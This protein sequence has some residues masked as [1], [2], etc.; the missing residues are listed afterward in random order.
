MKISLWNGFPEWI[1]LI[2]N[3][4]TYRKCCK[5]FIV[6]LQYIQNPFTLISGKN[7]SILCKFNLNVGEKWKCPETEASQRIKPLTS[8]KQVDL[9]LFF[10]TF[11]WTDVKLNNVYKHKDSRYA[12]I[13]RNTEAQER[14]TTQFQRRKVY[15]EPKQVWVAWEA[16]CQ[17]GEQGRCTHLGHANIFPYILFSNYSIA[18]YFLEALKAAC[19]SACSMFLVVSIFIYCENWVLFLQHWSRAQTSLQTFTVACATPNTRYT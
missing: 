14:S 9:L 1:R 5:A 2:Q 12:V 19:K 16:W 6:N 18:N 17:S 3:L 8:L 7:N 13:K 11:N 4:I 10:F 15:S